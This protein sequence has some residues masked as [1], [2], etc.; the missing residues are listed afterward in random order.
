V[1]QAQ[2]FLGPYAAVQNLFNLS[3]HLISAQHYS[4][5]RISAFGEWSGA[6]A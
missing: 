1:R 4:D 6:V 2:R 3:R 5:L